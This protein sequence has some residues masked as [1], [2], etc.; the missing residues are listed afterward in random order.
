MDN[1]KADIGFIGLAVMGQNLVQNIAS[2]GFSVAVYNRT[3]A[4]TREYI[5]TVDSENISPAYS[6]SDL[7]NSIKSPKRIML[8]V[9][10]GEAVD[11]V[12][13]QLLPNLQEGDAL[14]DMGNSNYKDTQRRTHQLTEKG[15]LYSGVGVSGGEEGALNGP[16]IMFGGSKELFTEVEALIKSISAMDFQGAATLTYVGPDGAGH[17]AKMVHN[18]I[19]YAMMQAISEAY[20]LLRDVFHK[21]PSEIAAVFANLNEGPLNSYLIQI[22]ADVLNKKDDLTEG[23]LIDKILD[24]AEQKGTGSWVSISALENGTALNILTEAVFARSL[25]ADKQTRI[26]LAE[27]STK[28]ELEK[29]SRDKNLPDDKQLHKLVEDSLLVSFYLAFI[30]GFHLLAKAETENNWQINLSELARIWQGGCIIRAELLK[31]LKRYTETKAVLIENEELF[32][33][34]NGKIPSLREL[35]LMAT[36]HALPLPVMQNSLLYFD[37]MINPNLPTNLI[38]GLRDYF[39]A[40][41]YKRTDREGIFHT[42]WD[43]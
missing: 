21:D 16:S 37:S 15:I 1:Q 41:T 32:K 10:A 4:I 20:F 39:G 43:D 27:V 14:L 34:I 24:V 35:A 18:G 22:T 12:I 33:M 42:N 11:E 7:C 3:A 28:N 29:N 26:K 19:E 23:F 17:Y 6:L 9:K 38:Q 36:S 25:S 13:D 2:K 40:H 8:M 5:E 31:D 30:Q